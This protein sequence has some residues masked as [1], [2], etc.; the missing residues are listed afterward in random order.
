MRGTGPRTARSNPLEDAIR[1]AAALI[2]ALPYIRAFRG[3]IFVVKFG[4][5]A[6]ESDSIMHCV[7]DDVIFLNSVGIKPVIVHG[8]GPA[9]SRRMKE[10][11]IEPKFVH[12]HRITD[13]NTLAIAE[14]VLVN[15]INAAIC[16][17]LEAMGGHPEPVTDPAAGAL[18]A[19]RRLIK[20]R[21]DNGSVRTLD[22][23]LVGNPL[24][25]DNDLFNKTLDRGRTPVVSPLAHGPNGETLN[26]NA[27]MVAGVIAAQLAAEKAVF[28]SNTHGIRT[29]LDDPDSLADTLTLAQVADLVSRS[30]IT[31]GMLPKVA[32]CRKALE[33]GVR[34][35]HIVDGR[36][37]H[38]L[39]LEIFTNRG[40][41]T[42]IIH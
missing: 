11:A 24:G 31:G 33:G 23:G 15:E 36:L 4:G 7:L 39:L 20:E 32:A 19:E 10:R 6:M 29:R 13:E 18:R 42:Q 1:K 5:A 40:V 21:L 9:I 35:T 38:S 8:G 37:K 22:L 27:D 34:K 25:I 16:K 26:C 2:E 12:G 41:G 3:T 14:D 17:R 28:L 30:I